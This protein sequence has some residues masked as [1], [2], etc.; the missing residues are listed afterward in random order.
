VLFRDPGAT[1]G[2]LNPRE[3]AELCAILSPFAF[4]GLS[5]VLDGIVLERTPISTQFEG[6]GI[7]ISTPAGCPGHAQVV[8][9]CCFR[10]RVLGK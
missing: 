1:V 9:D 10:S 5:G 2:V 7:G 4:Q 8:L 3:Y 6:R